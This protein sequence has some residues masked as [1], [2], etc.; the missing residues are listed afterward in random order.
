MMNQPKKILETSCPIVHP[1]FG[2]QAMGHYA[3]QGL[4]QT[5]VINN[6]LLQVDS[7]SSSLQ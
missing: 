5:I 3:T 1:L 7:V 4:M 6:K 2:K